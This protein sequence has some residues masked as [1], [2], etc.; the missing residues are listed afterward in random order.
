MLNGKLDGIRGLSGSLNGSS[1]V[2][3]KLSMPAARADDYE[4]LKNLPRINN[5]EVVGNKS[6]EQ[7]GLEECSNLEIDALFKNI[8]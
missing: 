7:Y 2:G 5:V 8:F 4:K 6:F 3:G 1:G